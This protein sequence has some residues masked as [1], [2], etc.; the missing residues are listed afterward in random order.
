[1]AVTTKFGLAKFTAGADNWGDAMNANLDTIDANLGG[2]GGVVQVNADWDAT[3]GVA[4]ILNKPA[5][6]TVPT[7]VSA[8]TNDAGYIEGS[9]LATV[10]TSGNYA[11]LS[12]KPTIAG[13]VNSDWNAISGMAEILNKPTLAAV[14]TSGA[15][16]DLSGKPTLATVATSGSYTDLSSKPSIPAAQV[17]SDWSAV[18]GVA[19]ILNKPTLATVATSGSY[20]DLGSKPSI[21]AAQVNSDWN[22]SSG[23]AQLLNKPTL[24]TVATSGSA[25]D[26]STGTLSNSRLTA[27]LVA[28]TGS[29]NT[30]QIAGA[31][32]GSAP[33]ISA[34]GTSDANVGINFTPKG[35][36][37][38]TVTSGNLALT[39]GNVT[40]A[41]NGT[42]GNGSGTVQFGGS[43]AFLI[44]SVS[45]TLKVGAVQQLIASSSGIG[46][47]VGLTTVGSL[48]GSAVDIRTDTAATS[49]ANK[50]SPIMNITGNYWTSSA[51]ANDYW[52][53]QNALAAS[54]ANPTSTLTF[55]HTGS[56]GVALIKIPQLPVYANNAAAVSGGLSAGTLYRTG[57]DPDQVCIVH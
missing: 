26:L 5:I 36:G 29:N 11:D 19:Q 8:F 24:A 3:S 25:S 54:G 40:V 12:G 4:E 56:T 47:G 35:T 22:A 33:V 17:N 2:G 27:P 1:M 6:P 49:G 37:A 21:P 28:G 15:Y 16:S 57:G 31:A 53:I 50:S 10:A 32:N 52:S 38:V 44:G 34:L 48:N 41:N 9:S 13:Q 46:M 45:L 42:F 23:V 51:S 20:N 18:S 7:G 14:A 39:S 43:N 30:L 55:T